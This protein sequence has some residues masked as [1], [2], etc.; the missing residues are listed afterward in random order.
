LYITGG[1]PFVVKGHDAILDIL[2]NSNLAHN[3]ILEYD[4]NLSVINDNLLNK[5]SKFK[6]VELSVSCDDTFLQYEYVRFP[7]KFSTLLENL[8]KIKERGFGVRHLS[9]CVGIYS[10]FAPLRLYDCFGESYNYS[11]RFLSG[12]Y[13]FDIEYLNDDLKKKVIH[14]Y[15][16]MNYN[17]RWKKYIVGH[18]ENTIGKHSKEVCDNHTLKFISYMNRLDELRQ[19]NWR[20]TFPDVSSL[21]KD[22]DKTS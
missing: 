2:I 12:P 21:L 16:S 13:S 11:I 8:K 9:T 5:L 22:Y 10:I 1:E 19:T 7:G 17:E 20:K 4:T 3:V 6:K 15:N 18:L 14:V